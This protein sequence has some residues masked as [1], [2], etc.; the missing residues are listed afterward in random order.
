MMMSD[1]KMQQE[2]NAP[3]CRKLDV[4]SGELSQITGTRLPMDV[5]SVQSATSAHSIDAAKLLTS[6]GRPAKSAL[7]QFEAFVLQ[8]FVSAIL[9]KEA[10]NVY[11][12]GLSGEMW[13]SMFAEKIAAQMAEHGGVGIADRLLKDFHVEGEEKRALQ[14]VRDPQYALVRG[15]ADAL[16]KAMLNE[17]QT[18]IFGVSAA[19]TNR[20]TGSE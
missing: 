12:K 1:W 11:G 7:V 16:A 17:A 13:Q 8:E 14:G 19:T 20:K 4:T 15:E 2:Y 18:E 5:T 6:T 9:P 10:E 3:A